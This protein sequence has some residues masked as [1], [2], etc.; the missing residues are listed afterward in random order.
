MLP[1]SSSCAHLPHELISLPPSYDQRLSTSSPSAQS[2]PQKDGSVSDVSLRGGEQAS[3]SNSPTQGGIGDDDVEDRHACTSTSVSAAEAAVQAAG[4]AM[5]HTGC[6]TFPNVCYYC[7]SRM[8]VDLA[9]P[10]LFRSVMSFL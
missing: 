10:K 3:F 6:D 8:L 2:S 1:S 9:P 5:F 4:D 7:T